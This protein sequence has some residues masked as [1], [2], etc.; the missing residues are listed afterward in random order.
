MGEPLFGIV[1][2]G[3]PLITEFQTVREQKGTERCSTARLK[4]WLLGVTHPLLCSHH[5]LA[6][7]GSLV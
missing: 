3:R 6:L 5:V 2:P 7:T 4:L 1:I